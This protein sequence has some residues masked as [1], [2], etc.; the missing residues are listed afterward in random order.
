MRSSDLKTRPL[1]VSKYPSRRLIYAL[2]QGL[3]GVCGLLSD[4]APLAAALANGCGTL[5]GTRENC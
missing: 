4:L 5:L 2:K 3:V 1:Q